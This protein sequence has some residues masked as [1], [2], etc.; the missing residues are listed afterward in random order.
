MLLLVGEAF[1][2]I[3]EL[4]AV[5]LEMVKR[6]VKLL[7]IRTEASLAIYCVVV[8]AA[9]MART[10]ASFLERACLRRVRGGV[11]GQSLLCSFSLIIRLLEIM[12]LS[13]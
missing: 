6:L 4:G 3:Y 9:V 10:L 13:C 12:I 8:C 7:A 5:R 11:L 2:F 1:L